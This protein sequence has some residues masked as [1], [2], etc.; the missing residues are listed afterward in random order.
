MSMF[1]LTTHTTLSASEDNGPTTQDAVD[2]A[3]GS[4]VTQ[5]VVHSDLGV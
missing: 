4:T 2:E 1:T 3:D 5:H